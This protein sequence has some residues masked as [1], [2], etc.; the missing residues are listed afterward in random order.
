YVR[1]T[2]WGACFDLSIPSLRLDSPK[3]TPTNKFQLT[4]RTV[5]GTAIDSN[6]LTG[7]Q[8]RATTNPAQSPSAWTLLTNPLTLTNGI[9][10]VTNL[11][12]RISPNRFFIISEPK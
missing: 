5:D 3:L 1:S 9:I 7:M 11:D 2:Y 10:T 12:G 8:L 4:V 6:R